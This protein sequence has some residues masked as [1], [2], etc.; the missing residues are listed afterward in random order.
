MG[1]IKAIF[2]SQNNNWETPKELFEKLNDEFNFTLDATA[3]Q[4]NAKCQRYY[5]EE[6]NCL[7]QHPTNESIFMNPPYSRQIKLFV[8]WIF[9]NYKNNKVIVLVIPAR[10]DTEYF[11]KY[12]Y[13]IAELRFVRGRVKFE[14]DGK[15]YGSSTF[16]TMI[17]IFRGENK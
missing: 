3:S 11:H 16:P 9:E 4:K 2:S 15:R 1:N 13:G 6:M 8:K 7:V 5:D 10:T 14:L 12:I 17:C